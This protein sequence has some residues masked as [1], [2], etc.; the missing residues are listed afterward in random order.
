M[1][2]QGKK[3]YRVYL[4]EENTEYVKSFLEG[5]RGTGGFSA[6]VDSMVKATADTL[7]ESGVG[8]KSK[9]TWGKLI[10]MALIGLRKEM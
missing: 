5:T 7:R 9:M 1:A 6:L 10:R 3:M 8:A 4:D 2:I